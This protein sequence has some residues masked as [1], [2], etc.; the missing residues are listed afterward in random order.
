ME[1]SLLLS[2]NELTIESTAEKVKIIDRSEQRV[3]IKDIKL[4]I[5]RPMTDNDRNGEA[6]STTSYAHEWE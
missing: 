4:N 6:G 5:W 3:V 2:T 1:G